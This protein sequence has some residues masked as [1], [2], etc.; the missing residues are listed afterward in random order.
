MELAKLNRE[1]DLA[2]GWVTDEP[3]FNSWRKQDTYRYFEVSRQVLR[4]TQPPIQWVPGALPT[5]VNRPVSEPN[6][7]PHCYAIVTNVWC[8]ASVYLHMLSWCVQEQFYA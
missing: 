3:W 5:R 4:A 2:T 6:D 8:H 1:T 7:L